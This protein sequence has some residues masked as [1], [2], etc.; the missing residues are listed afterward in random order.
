MLVEEAVELDKQVRHLL[1]ELVVADL[2]VPR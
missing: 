2:E 1:V